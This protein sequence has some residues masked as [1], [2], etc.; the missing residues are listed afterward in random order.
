MSPLQ[1]SIHHMDFNLLVGVKAGEWVV[2]DDL[3]LPGWL[4][5]ISG[6]VNKNLP[7]FLCLLIRNWQGPYTNIILLKPNFFLKLFYFYFLPK[8]GG[9]RETLVGLNYRDPIRSW[10]HFGE[11]NSSILVEVRCAFD[12]TLS[13]GGVLSFP[14]KGLGCSCSFCD[15]LSSCMIQNK[16][17]K[18]WGMRMDG[19]KILINGNKLLLVNFD[20]LVLFSR[21][22]QRINCPILLGMHSA[23]WTFLFSSISFLKHFF[24]QL[25]WHK[26]TISWKLSL[27]TNFLPNC[28]HSSEYA[29]HVVPRDGRKKLWNSMNHFL[30]QSLKSNTHY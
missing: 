25:A 27:K 3:K 5:G 16:K 11:V 1:E 10:P 24:S 12:R 19:C 14:C 4:G 15:L 28:Y 22:W 8:T 23:P 2:W 20:T 17:R 30:C 26:V 21:E 13:R 7:L 6:P 18:S 9:P 29:K